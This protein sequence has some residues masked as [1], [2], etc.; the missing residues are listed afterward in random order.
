MN[1]SQGS[2]L[3]Y[4]DMESWRGPVVCRLQSLLG[5]W[6]W[7]ERSGAQAAVSRDLEQPRTFPALESSCTL[8][9]RELSAA[10]QSAA[11]WRVLAG[12]DSA[13]AGITSAVAVSP[14]GVT[15]VTSRH[16]LE[17]GDIATPALHDTATRDTGTPTAESEETLQH[18]CTCVIECWPWPPRLSR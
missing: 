12:G 1:M 18:Q 16:S 9:G 8:I 17:L 2:P 4:G 7:R 3:A 13:A 10:S 5:W 15:V 6:M 14:A 11:G